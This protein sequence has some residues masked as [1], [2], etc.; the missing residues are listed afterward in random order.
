MVR[1]AA[2]EAFE[3]MG[4]SIFADPWAARDH[5]VDVIIGKREL[6]DLLT[7]DAAGPLGD[8]EARRAE[9]L[10]E[11]QRNS[12]SMFTSC[13]WFFNDIG[14]IETI[15]VLA[16]AARTLDLLAS[17]GQ[18]GPRDAFLAI[19]QTAASNDPDIGTGADVFSGVYSLTTKRPKEPVGSGYSSD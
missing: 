7:Q 8:E 13:G 2:D 6:T 1:D 10:L 4:A 17:L 12:M 11:L 9:D 3:R 15:Q 16:Y 19:L 14:G 5:Y 18:P